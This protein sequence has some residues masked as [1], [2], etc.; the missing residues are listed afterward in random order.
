MAKS[1]KDLGRH[2]SNARAKIAELEKKAF[3]D[4]LKKNAA[5]HEELA[6]LKSELNE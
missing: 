5:L 1:K 6:R 4:P 2:K 3:M